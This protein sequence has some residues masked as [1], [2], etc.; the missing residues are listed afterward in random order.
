MSLR[1]IPAIHRVTHGIALFLDQQGAGVSQGEAHILAH[2]AANGDQ[3]VGQCHE[4]LAHR[5]S[6]LTG[7]LDRLEER[8]AIERVSHPKDRRTF[9]VKLT[10][11]GRKLAQ[12]VNRLLTDIE[13][14]ALT[15]VKGKQVK[16]FEAVLE[17]LVAALA[18]KPARNGRK[19]PQAA[20]RKATG[21]EG[22]A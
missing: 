2:L 20:G 13:A 11:P 18:A 1:L 5:R 17:G 15:E 14:R 16:G 7:I 3:T 21:G 8:G 4:A 19:N 9:L 6:T 10:P 22:G 12:E